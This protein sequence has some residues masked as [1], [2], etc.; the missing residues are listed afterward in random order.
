MKIVTTPMC[1]DVLK[2]AGIWNLILTLILI[3]PMQT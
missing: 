3:L 1:K 2:L